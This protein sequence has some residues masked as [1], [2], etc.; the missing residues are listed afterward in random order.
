MATMAMLVHI[1]NRV[2]FQ[3]VLSQLS[4]VPEKGG[5]WLVPECHVFVPVQA[6]AADNTGS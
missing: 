3:M 2:V 6:D 4:V 5:P 1:P